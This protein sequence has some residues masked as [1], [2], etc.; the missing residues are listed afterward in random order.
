[1][2]LFDRVLKDYFLANIENGEVTML[3]AS[4]RT[5]ISVPNLNAC[6]DVIK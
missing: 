4:D 3:L 2:Y 5:V 6:K 1:M